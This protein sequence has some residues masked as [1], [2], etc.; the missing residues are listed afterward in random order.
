[1]FLCKSIYVKH[2]RYGAPNQ[3][4]FPAFFHGLFDFLYAQLTFY[5]LNST[6]YMANQS[7]FMW[8]TRLFILPTRY[9]IWPTDHFLYGQLITFYMGNTTFFMVNFRIF[10]LTTMFQDTCTSGVVSGLYNRRLVSS[11]GRAPDC[12][13]GGRGF[14]PQTGPTLRVLK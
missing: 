9:F 10:S 5:M 3:S 12:S 13:A 4:I 1:M 11:V 8:S 14:E 2:P 7:L 6:F